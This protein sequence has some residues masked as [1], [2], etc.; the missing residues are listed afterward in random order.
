MQSF[1]VFMILPALATVLCSIYLSYMR[2]SPDKRKAAISKYKKSTPLYEMYSRFYSARFL[3]G[4]ILT[5]VFFV[6]QAIFDMYK[7]NHTPSLLV[8]SL[9]LF[10]SM[11]ASLVGLYLIFA[12][13]KTKY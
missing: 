7:M 3:A 2:I 8:L 10:S 12:E 9:V 4:Q 13:F 11:L 6:I 1:F 5:S